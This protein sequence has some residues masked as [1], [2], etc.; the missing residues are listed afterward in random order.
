MIWAKKVNSRKELIQ[1]SKIAKLWL[2][3]VEKYEK[4]NLAKFAYFAYVCI[5]CRDCYHFNFEPKMVTISARNTNYYIFQ[6][7][8]HF[9]RAVPRRDNWGVYIHIFIFSS[10][11]VKTI[12]F[13]RNPSGR[14]R[15]YEYAPPTPTP[16]LSNF[17]ILLISLFFS[18]GVRFPSLSFTSKNHNSL[19]HPYR[20]HQVISFKTV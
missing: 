18:C 20:N 12:A 14:T 6:A 1:I 19:F 2:R 5:T 7:S 15:I 17:P 10:H 8:Q 4:Y 16:Q 9:T 11:T 3:N 13:K